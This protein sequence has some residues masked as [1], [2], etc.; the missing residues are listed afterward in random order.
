MLRIGF[1]PNFKNA[2]S[3]LLAADAEGIHAFLDAIARATA[4]PSKAIPLH[5]F[6]RVSAK[7]PA[8]LYVVVNAEAVRFCSGQHVLP[9]RVREPVCSPGATGHRE[10]ADSN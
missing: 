2:D 10:Y 6:A 9:R 4:N 7:R 8:S 1:F 3:V 5:E